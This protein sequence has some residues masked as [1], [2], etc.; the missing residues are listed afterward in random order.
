MICV[1]GADDHR[2]VPLQRPPQHD[3]SWGSAVRLRNGS[4]L[5]IGEDRA[6]GS[7][8][9]R[10]CLQ[11]DALSLAELEHLLVV[12]LRVPLH[13]MQLDGVLR[14][15]KRLLQL[16]DVVVRD[17]DGFHNTD[18]LELLHRPPSILQ[19]RLRCRGERGLLAGR[20]ASVEAAFRLDDEREVHQQEVDVL[21]AVCAK[22]TEHL[23]VVVGALDGGIIAN[24]SRALGGDEHILPLL[25]ALQQRLRNGGLSA[26]IVGAV[27]VGPADVEPLVDGPARVLLDACVV[28]VVTVLVAATPRAHSHLRNLAA[29]SQGKAG[30]RVGLVTD[31]AC[32]QGDGGNQ[33][34]GAQHCGEQWD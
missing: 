22:L 19:L 18:P 11:L 1:G 4:N 25:A 6:L 20:R 3:L 10:P 8:Q 13:L 15:L 34:H 28:S 2:H 5:G 27:N 14:S 33:P 12:R 30:D 21:H 32:C 29:T 16:G 9:R 31:L 24:G 17:P 23:Q 26:V 7:T